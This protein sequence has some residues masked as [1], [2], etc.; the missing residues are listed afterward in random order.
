MTVVTLTIAGSD[1]GGG[2]GIQADLKTFHA[3]GTFGTSALTAVTAQDTGG[4]RDVRILDPGIVEGQIRAVADDLSPSAT[5]TG[6]LGDAATVRTVARTL[7]DLRL[8]GL[9]VDPVMVAQSGD[10]LLAEE[11]VEI[12]AAELLPL[13][14]IATPNLDEAAALAGAAIEDEAGMRDAARRILDLGPSAVLLKGGHLE[15]E[16]VVDLYHDGSSWREWRT[17][18]LR[19]RAGHGTGCTLSAGIAAGLALGRS[20]LQAVDVA[21]RFTREALATAPGLGAG[22]SPLNHWAPVPEPAPEL[23]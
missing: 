22:S 7:A 1:S 2:A 4:V 15:A 18:R 10:P 14:E 16:E 19:T 11:A 3:F 12:L 6:M 5:K 23:R 21:V 13:A 17:P 8:P 20:P 9:V